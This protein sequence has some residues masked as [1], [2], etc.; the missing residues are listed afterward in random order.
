MTNEEKTTKS[1]AKEPCKTCEMIRNN[2]GFGP[3]HNGSKSCQ[4]GSLASG[5]N[6]SHC[7]C[8]TCF[9]KFSDL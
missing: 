3:R 4:S 1:E 2:G 7:T 9:W 6:R 5:G 8:D